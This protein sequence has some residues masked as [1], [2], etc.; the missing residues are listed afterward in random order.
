MLTADFSVYICDGRCTYRNII[1]ASNF[2]CAL[3]VGSW[4]VTTLAFSPNPAHTYNYYIIRVSYRYADK[5]NIGLYSNEF[6]VQ[7]SFLHLPLPEIPS[8]YD[9]EAAC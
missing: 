1:R 6:I 7:F 3:S 9:L 4:V 5:W 8:H 2:A